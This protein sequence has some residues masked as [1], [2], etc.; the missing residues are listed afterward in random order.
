M[1]DAMKERGILLEN[2]LDSM[3]KTPEKPSES[4]L[5]KISTHQILSNEPQRIISP[6]NIKPNLNAILDKYAPQVAVLDIKTEKLRC[7]LSQ[8]I[9][10]TPWRSECGHIFEEKYALERLKSKDYRCPVHGCGK[11]LIK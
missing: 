6:K 10:K 1:E 2:I 11:R 7:P 3:F 8:G 9:I 4:L 5:K